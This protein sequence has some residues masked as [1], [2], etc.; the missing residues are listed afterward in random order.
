MLQKINNMT[1][2]GMLRKKMKQV[3]AD[4]G[5]DYR[6]TASVEI[7]KKLTEELKR[8]GDS[9]DSVLGFASFDTEVNLWP[10]YEYLWDAERKC[11]F[12]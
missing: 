5:E 10:L 6:E 1:E 9:F 3:R 4:L 2:L 7:C 8:Y 11:T 12:R